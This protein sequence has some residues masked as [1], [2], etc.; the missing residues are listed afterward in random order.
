MNV[1][2]ERF[3]VLFLKLLKMCAR[4]PS[5]DKLIRANHDMK[6]PKVSKFVGIEE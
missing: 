5:A 2:W 1:P 4:K 6:T 3:I